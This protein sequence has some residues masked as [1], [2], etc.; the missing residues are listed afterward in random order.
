MAKSARQEGLGRDT[1]AGGSWVLNPDDIARIVSKKMRN[2]QRKFTHNAEAYANARPAKGLT[3]EN[4]YVVSGV[5]LVDHPQKFGWSYMPPSEGCYRI[6]PKGQLRPWSWVVVHSFGYTWDYYFFKKNRAQLIPPGDQYGHHPARW[7][8]AIQQLCALQLSDVR[9]PQSRVSIHWCVSRRGDV[10][11]SCGVND[12]AFHGGGEIRISKF[13]NNHVSVGVELEPCLSRYRQ[14][15]GKLSQPYILPYTE[16]QMLAFAITCKKLQTFQPNLENFYAHHDRSGAGQSG[17]MAS[18]RAHRGGYIQHSDLFSKKA[19]ANAQF[20]IQPGSRGLP[21]NPHLT[22]HVSGWDTLWNLMSKMR[23]N[24]ATD[25]FTKKLT[26]SEFQNVADLSNAMMRTENAGQRAI[27]GA[28][29]DRVLGLQRA[30]SMQAQDRRALYKQ[31][32]NHATTMNSI[33]AKSTAVV[34][35]QATAYAG[36]VSTVGGNIVTYNEK[37]GLWSDEQAY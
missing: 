5:G 34:A 29:R 21:G 7:F 22:N 11:W 6:W 16:K 32:V 20:D 27:V 33:V 23:F 28:Q 17:F 36:K 35:Q 37:T 18:V 10:V 15:N 3:P 9:P 13:G 2:L 14:K 31:G 24:L 1:T 30:S 26:D 4:R 12:L 19:D 8:A 25:I